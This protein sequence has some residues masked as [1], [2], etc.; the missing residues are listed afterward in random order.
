MTRARVRV[1][2]IRCWDSEE[3]RRVYELSREDYQAVVREGGL[4]EQRL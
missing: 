2:I 1:A 4:E 3:G